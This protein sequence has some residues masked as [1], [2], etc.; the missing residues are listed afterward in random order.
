M[1]DHILQK[2]RTVYWQYGNVTCAGYPLNDIDTI[3]KDGSINETSALS[4]LVRGVSQ[5]HDKRNQIH[6][7][8]RLIF[9]CHNVISILYVTHDEYLL[10]FTFSFHVDI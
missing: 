9:T 8:L 3:G 10:N 4:I 5:I 1:F 2:I 7:Y 6:I